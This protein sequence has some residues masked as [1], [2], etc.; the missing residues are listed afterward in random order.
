MISYLW[1]TGKTD[2]LADFKAQ[3]D[4]TWVVDSWILDNGAYIPNPEI[5]MD[6]FFWYFDFLGPKI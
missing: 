3:P 4:N 6:T 2:R 5:R 1:L